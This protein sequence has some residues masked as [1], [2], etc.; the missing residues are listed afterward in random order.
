M[1]GVLGQVLPWPSGGGQ[2][3]LGLSVPSRRAQFGDRWPQLYIWSGGSRVALLRL[4][5]WNHWQLSDG[6]IS[7]L[8]CLSEG[9]LQGFPASQLRVSEMHIHVLARFLHGS[10]FRYGQSRFGVLRASQFNGDKREAWFR[11]KLWVIW[12]L[13]SFL[14]TGVRAH[15]QNVGTV[16]DM[17]TLRPSFRYGH[18]EQTCWLCV[19]FICF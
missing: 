11:A 15:R 17:P 16:W 14:S 9:F 2:D 19:Y 3:A 13:S 8:Q 12:C 7:S 18:C 6:H 5:E 10:Y 4:R 1:P